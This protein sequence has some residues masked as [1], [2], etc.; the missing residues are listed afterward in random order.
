MKNNNK[1]LI[2]PDVHL[3]HEQAEKII[4]KEKPDEIIFLGDAFDDFDDTPQMVYETSEW[5]KWS[6][7]QKN[8]SH[9]YG[10]HE[11]HYRFPNA[12]NNRCG[13]YEQ[14]KSI[15]INDIVKPDDWNKLKFFHVLDNKWLLSHGGIHPYWIDP[16]KFREEGEVSI[17]L[18][19]L[20]SKLEQDTKECVKL[21][22]E[23]RYNWIC[24]AGFS[25]SRS[26]FVGGLLWLDFG[27]EFHPIRGIHQI[28][29][30]TPSRDYVRWSFYKENDKEVSFSINGCEPVLSDK[31]SYNV[32]FDS[33]PALKWYGIYENK[34]LNIN[35]FVE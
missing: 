21:L 10:N 12:T 29:G 6:L 31:S 25:R 5:F 3:H 20:V 19:K 2:V 4:S 8:R 9:I 15:T 16:V 23:N 33:Y 18:D 26:P 32:C 27:Q 30:H 14:Y 24:I 34:S 17:T 7:N 13:G 22:E 28:V 1:I 35:S 11:I